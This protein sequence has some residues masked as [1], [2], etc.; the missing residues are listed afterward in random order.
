MMKK[1]F[2]S[3]PLTA[4]ILTALTFAACSDSD[5]IANGNSVKNG[6]VS[7]GSVQF[8][9]YMGT[10]A[11]E[12]RA[13]EKGIID[14]E[15]LKV[16][17][18]GFGVMAFNTGAGTWAT[19]GTSTKPNFMYNEKVYWDGASKWIYDNVKYWP[20]DFNKGA[21]DRGENS[22]GTN[23]ADGSGNN[24]NTNK[25]SFFAYAPYVEMVNYS[26]TAAADVNIGGTAT[27]SFAPT[28]KD[29]GIV[30][31]TYNDK[32]GDPYLKYI[33][34]DATS[35][36]AVDLLWGM[37]GNTSGYDLANGAT[38]A[39]IGDYNTDLSKQTVE[40]TVNF[41]FKHALAKIA[42]HDPETSTGT[43][44]FKTGLQVILDIDKDGKLTGGS[45]DDK[46][47]V[48]IND[49]LIEDWYTYNKRL[50]PSTTEKSD[51]KTE[52]WFDIVTGTWS[53]VT[54]DANGGAT[55]TS[56]TTTT[57]STGAPGKLNPDIAEPT[58][59]IVGDGTTWTLDDIARKGVVETTPKDVYSAD[60]DVPAIFMIPAPT[61]TGTENDQ[62]LV[63]TVTYTVRTYDSH[64]ATI[65]D[66]GSSSGKWTK[67]AQTITNK[68]TIPGGSLAPNKYYKLL[69]H[70]GLTSIKFSAT[71][72]DWDAASNAD[73][74]GD[75]NV[76]EPKDADKEV[77]LPSNTLSVDRVHNVEDAA[78]QINMTTSDQTITLPYAAGPYNVAVLNA[79]PSKTPDITLD[80]TNV[81]GATVTNKNGVVTVKFNEANNTALIKDC[82][83]FTL[84][85]DGGNST[86][87]TLKQGVGNIELSAT[88]N[89]VNATGATTTITA[90]INGL[91]LTLADGDIKS[92]TEG[93]TDVKDNCTIN[94]G[95]ITFPNNETAE[96]KT[97]TVTVGKGNAADAT[98]NIEQKSG[99]ITATPDNT[100][101]F[102]A[103]KG[104]GSLV[105]VTVRDSQ[106][107]TVDFTDTNNKTSVTVMQGSTDM[108]GLCTI[109]KTATGVTVML[110]ANTGNTTRDFT[111]TVKVN[112][113][114]KTTENITQNAAS[115]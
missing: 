61:G 18:Y 16:S 92:V 1:F 8:S 39:S 52:G 35:T 97:Y 74:D 110:P 79:S 104:A 103:S 6:A 5:T 30:A 4:A 41:L 17:S 73:A 60:S 78:Q 54:I 26:T 24:N 13:G 33:L 109:G 85:D 46:T 34:K 37:R 36:N 91:P 112:D 82:G 27:K 71:V 25:L 31:A 100:T 10:N 12:T 59:S 99:T 111:I 72:A 89:L 65:N 115:N 102:S 2:F 50:N 70:L 28:E 84:T 93:V 98:I 48:T 94:G 53:D 15:V 42:G 47:L 81:S 3:S 14:T 69:M 68:V 55:Y 49:V 7:D 66:V 32:E 90:T 44:D 67:V 11:Q 106:N 23:V 88:A 21:V 76:D 113:S 87:V 58:T 22:E 40:E 38:E 114:E 29:E 77:Y 108:T 96:R 83:S 51:L 20:N 19:Q 9:T 62:T 64:L 86:T 105:T 75:G 56:G 95:S 101:G 45:K 57:N 107:N 80:D 63:V 43:G